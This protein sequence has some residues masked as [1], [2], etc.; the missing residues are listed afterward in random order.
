[1]RRQT[2]VFVAKLSA[3]SNFTVTK[4][5]VVREGRAAA[6]GVAVRFP[7]SLVLCFG[8][9]ADDVVRLNSDVDSFYIIPYQREL[10]GVCS[11]TSFF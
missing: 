8:R 2:R 10:S 11:A 9:Y 1:M 6:L 7:M 5:A 4:R 3:L